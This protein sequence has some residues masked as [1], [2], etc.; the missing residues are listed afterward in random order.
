MRQLK[1]VEAAAMWFYHDEYAAQTLSAIDFYRQL[2]FDKQQL[3]EKMVDEIV[4][5]QP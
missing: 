1:R 4:E 2:P 5:A 3:M